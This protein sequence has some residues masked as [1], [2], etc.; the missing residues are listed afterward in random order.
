MLA[1]YFAINIHCDISEAYHLEAFNFLY[2]TQELK[3]HVLEPEDNIT[4]TCKLCSVV[5]CIFLNWKIGMLTP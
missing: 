4:F 2:T 3:N 1:T 5:L